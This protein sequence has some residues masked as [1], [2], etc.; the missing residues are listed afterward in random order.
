MCATCGCDPPLLVGFAQRKASM[1]QEHMLECRAPSSGSALPASEA[2]LAAAR[3]PG[4]V[5]LARRPDPEP[6]GRAARS[7]CAL[8]PEL[9]LQHK[10]SSMHQEHMLECRAPSSGSALPASEAR[11]AAARAPGSVALARRPDPEPGG[12]AARSLC[13]LRPELELQHKYSSMHQEHMLECRAPSSGSALPASE[14]RLAAARAPGS[15]ALARRPDP[16]PG[17]RAA[18][19]L[20]ALRPELEL[21]HKYSSMH[22]EHMLECRAPSSGSALPASEAR[23]AAARA[24]GSVALARRPDPEPGGRAARSLCALR[25]ELELQHKY[26]SMHQEHMLECRAPS[27]GSALP[28][29][30]ARLAAARAPGS[31]ALA[32]RPDPEPGGRAARSLCALRPELELQHKYSSMHQEH[33]LECRA[34]SSGSALPASEARLAAARA[35]GSVALARRPDPEPGGRAARSLCAL[36]PELELQHKYSSMH[37]EHMLECRAP[38]SGSALPASEARLAAARA[39]GSVALARRPDPEPGGRAARS[40]CA[41]RPELELQHKYSSMQQGHMQNA[42][43]S[44]LGARIRPPPKLQTRLQARGLQMAAAERAF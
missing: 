16:E 15:V 11:L 8:R 34:P 18:R 21:Q 10:Y 19:S 17:G 42:V 40:L 25:P 27:S 41:L 7:L 23:L 30:E 37:Q 33:M 22:Q 38:S 35:P 26:S 2:R 29:S 44:T 32:R 24:P 3:A 36:R 9:E 20:C 1:H 5:A 28:A 6:G 13:A 39:P 4:S 12:R 43:R 31:V 14:A